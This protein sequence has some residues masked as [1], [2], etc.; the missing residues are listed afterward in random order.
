MDIKSEVQE[1]EI[2]FDSSSSIYSE[3]P[4]NVDPREE[5]A[6]DL[7][8]R[9]NAFTLDAETIIQHQPQDT[10]LQL[11]DEIRD[12]FLQYQHYGSMARLKV[13][14]EKFLR[15]NDRKGRMKFE[16]AE[17]ENEN[18]GKRYHYGEAF[19]ITN[20][21]EDDENKWG[22]EF[23][24]DPQTGERYH[25]LKVVDPDSIPYVMTLPWD[26]LATKM[27]WPA[28]LAW[29]P[30]LLGRIDSIFSVADYEARSRFF[31]HVLRYGPAPIIRVGI[32]EHARSHYGTMLQTAEENDLG[33][34]QETRSF[35]RGVSET[36]QTL[37]RAEQRLL[38]RGCRIAEDAVNIFFED[39]LDSRVGYNGM[40]SF[41][42]EREFQYMMHEKL[43]KQAKERA[44]IEGKMGTEHGFP[45]YQHLGQNS[46]PALGDRR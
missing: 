17:N 18:S 16:Q 19:K 24:Y 37:N 39:L 7:E 12:L 8:A 23:F 26:P 44:K 4:P 31:H 9:L 43:A 36:H 5:L 46:I 42:I 38:A 29:P 22:N 28:H 34:T 40:R 6:E 14:V 27:L 10:Q 25:P 41:M 2:D 45:G 32:E 1:D 13:G 30:G 20:T 11:F 21:A 15:L 33:L 35:L 3:L